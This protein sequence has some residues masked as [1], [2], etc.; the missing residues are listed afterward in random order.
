MSNLAN[1]APPITP[2][3]A[4][5][6]QR[7]ATQSRMARIEREKADDRQRDIEARA[8]AL[9]MLPE[10]EERRVSRTKKQID[11]LLDDMEG[12]SLKDRLTISRTIADLWKLVQPTAGVSKPSRQRSQAI[13][14][15]ISSQPGA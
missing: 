14:Q 15:P 9:A 5:E 7:R 3:T 10:P 4:R 6:Y 8:L 11:R 12:A 2:E 1:L 13:S